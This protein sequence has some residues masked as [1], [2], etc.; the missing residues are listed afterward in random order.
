MIRRPPRSTQSR[1]SAA[2][3]VYK[4]QDENYLKYSPG[5]LTMSWNESEGVNAGPGEVLFTIVVKAKNAALLRDMLSLNNRVTRTEAYA[6]TGDIQNVALHFVETDSGFALYQNTPNP[7]KGET[8]IGFKLPE[9]TAATI[10]IYDVT[11]RMIK[12]IESDYGAGYNEVR[13]KS[14]DLGTTGVLSVSYTH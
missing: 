8:V 7:Y 14:V 4:R 10:T 9:A 5:V 11:G 3:D 6:G 13:V 1:S 2:S 12:R